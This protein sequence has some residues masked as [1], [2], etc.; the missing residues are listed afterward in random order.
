VISTKQLN[1]WLNFRERYPLLIASKTKLLRIKRAAEIKNQKIPELHSI[2]HNLKCARE[3]NQ[4]ITL[5][6]EQYNLS[7]CESTDTPELF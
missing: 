7:T 2:G 3:I 5:Y 1:L 4:P 6:Q